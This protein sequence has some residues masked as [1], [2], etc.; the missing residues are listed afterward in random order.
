MDETAEGPPHP[1]RPPQ[2]GGARRIV[3][4]PED[5][6]IAGVCS[7]LAD[8]L[9]IDVTVMR[10][11][12]VGLALITPAALI[13]YLVAAVAVPERRPDQ[14]RVRARQVHLGN[15][16]HP[17]VAVGAVVAIAVLLDDAW[18]LRP[19]PAGVALVGIGVWLVVQNRD[20]EPPDPHAGSGEPPWWAA[21]T[22]AGADAAPE[23]APTSQDA[24]PAAPGVV[25]VSQHSSTVG[26]GDT[27][28][29]G[30]PA[31]APG[32]PAPREGVG[33]SGEFPPPASPWWS[34]ASAAP[35]ATARPVARPRSRAGSVAV[36]LLLVGAGS[37]WLLASLDVVTVGTE[38]VLALGLLVVG[39]GL[40]VTSRWGRARVLIPL[41][42]AMAAV[43]VA[44]EVIDVPVRA[45]T[46][47]RT[48]VVDTPGQLD[49]RHE[50]FAGE[51]TLDLTDAPLAAGRTTEVDAVVGMGELR[52]LLPHDAVVEVEATAGAGEVTAPGGPEA[53]ESGVR[54]DTSFVL[55]P[56]DEPG[57]D[58]DRAEDG[59]G[60]RGDPAPRL[61]LDLAVGLGDIEVTRG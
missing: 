36:A 4:E 5:R 11:A 46:G 32:E 35:P 58:A 16:P 42:F 27:T 29:T 61:A 40:L 34:G 31:P 26:D 37:L 51:L 38:V 48:V 24:T 59:P 13:A 30:E 18:W 50:L 45:G 12:A 9:G 10:V 17:L 19:F 8:H 49:T 1:P 43:L 41:G 7:G 52:V 6:K 56:P 20:D 22:A 55:E 53:N 21:S 39:A 28:L 25:S 54:V 23:D 44:G 15:V 2:G 57:A 14:P 60:P 3:R 47:D 33:P